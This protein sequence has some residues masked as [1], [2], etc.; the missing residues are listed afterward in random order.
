[1]GGGSSGSP[2]CVRIFRIRPWLRFDDR[3]GP[4]SSGDAPMLRRPV[5]GAA[6]SFA[7]FVN[8]RMASLRPR[9]LWPPATQHAYRCLPV[10]NERR[11]LAMKRPVLHFPP[12]VMSPASA[13]SSRGAR[14]VEVVSLPSIQLHRCP[15]IDVW[16]FSHQ[17]TCQAPPAADRLVGHWGV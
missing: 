10:R 16:P 12:G 5:A 3:I 8:Q 15:V 4:Q 6:P 9:L 1:M 17:K 11:W 2:R 7:R 14:Y 13:E